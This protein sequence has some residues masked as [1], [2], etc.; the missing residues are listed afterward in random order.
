MSSTTTCRYCRPSAVVAKAFCESANIGFNQIYLDRPSGDNDHHIV[1]DLMTTFGFRSV[2]TFI[3]LGDD[4][5]MI[6]IQVG[7]MDTHRQFIDFI[8]TE[9]IKEEK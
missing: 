3:L 6:N 9:I 1:N 8:K 7:A 5:R 4:D 2:P